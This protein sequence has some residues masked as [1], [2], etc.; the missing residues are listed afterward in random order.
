MDPLWAKA[1]ANTTAF[2]KNQGKK[3]EKHMKY[4]CEKKAK[5]NNKK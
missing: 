2:L 1:T 3:R 4:I 5:Q